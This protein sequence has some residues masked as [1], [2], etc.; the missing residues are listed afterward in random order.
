MA[1]HH[2]FYIA[3]G[4][5]CLV[6]LSIPPYL[7]P[8]LPEAFASMVAIIFLDL[9]SK[10]ARANSLTS[11]TPS[12]LLLLGSA[13]VGS[14]SLVAL[15]AALRTSLL[16]LFTRDKAAVKTAWI[17]I[18]PILASTLLASKAGHLWLG[19][20]LYLVLV[21]AIRLSSYSIDYFR[22]SL[23]TLLWAGALYLSAAQNTGSFVI[24]LAVLL[25]YYGWSDRADE[26]EK[27]AE[28]FVNQMHEADKALT[29]VKEREELQSEKFR[30]F[31]S[32][33]S[34]LDEFQKQALKA[35]S[36]AELAFLAVR[37]AKGQD[38]SGTG[39]VVTTDGEVLFSEPGFLLETFGKLPSDFKAGK[40]QRSQDGTRIVFPLTSK[41]LFLWICDP[42]SRSEPLKGEL[43][44]LT[45]E[46]AHLICRIIGQRQELVKL[47]QERTKALEALASSQSQLIQSGKMAAIGQMAAG[48]AHELNSPLAAIVLQ[49]QLAERKLGK[50]ATDGLSL[51]LAT[52]LR[53]ADRAQT[54]IKNLLTFSRLSDGSRQ[55]V[56]LSRLVEE[57][58]SL[59]EGPIHAAGA[60][61]SLG[62]DD[63]ISL[64]L[65][66]QDFQHVLTNIILNALDA[67]NN[68]PSERR[69][70]IKSFWRENEAVLEL[71]N[72]GPPLAEDELMKLFE[73]FFTTKEA[74]KGTG[75]GLS[76][77]Y[78]LIES[79]KGS[80]TAV[81]RS[82]WVVFI[83]SIPNPHTHSK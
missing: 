65:N 73:P 5:A 25:A 80:L 68:R 48:I 61:V 11:A 30:D 54:I 62:L 2:W 81:N 16:Y 9:Q 12:T 82:G 57:A 66:A 43:F 69:I 60:K 7:P 74:G 10:N 55:K 23:L 64:E 18:T 38:E 3:I 40:I 13:P 28:A 56:A 27:I 33:Q 22:Q 52:S 21:S 36:L 24:A 14:A 70:D 76:V 8:Y 37:S 20:I 78:Q 32:L 15:L 17:Q 58:I 83:I 50:G 63:S 77:S 6:A 29:R 59:A 34:I 71:A 51:T 41:I 72:N 46:R 75:L 26:V 45:L 35:D 19:A 42:H 53:A 4:L 47:L 67:L 39:A 31:V 1:L 44:R 79:L 49:L